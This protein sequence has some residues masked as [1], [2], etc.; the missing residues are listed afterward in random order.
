MM[1]LRSCFARFP[2]KPLAK[3]AV[4]LVIISSS[5]VGETD[6]PC[7]AADGAITVRLHALHEQDDD[8]TKIARNIAWQ[9]LTAARIDCWRGRVE[10]GL[11]TYRSIAAALDNLAPDLAD[12]GELRARD[13]AEDHR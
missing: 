10:R 5:A 11:A 12:A 7:T 8:R 13:D 1:C 2:A 3:G 6:S 9:R 4:A